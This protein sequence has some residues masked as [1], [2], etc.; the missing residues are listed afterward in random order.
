MAETTQ[1]SIS[2]LLNWFEENKVTYN[3]EALEIIATQQRGSKLVCGNGL[4]VVARRDLIEDEPLVVIPK[5][6][7]ISSATSALANI[8]EDEAVSGSLALCITVMYEIS[9]GEESP[10]FGYL[11]SLP[12]QAD[13]PLLWNSEAQKWLEGTDVGKWV[14]R[15]EQSLRDDFEIV[16]GLVDQYPAIFVTNGLV[17]WSDFGCFLRVTSLVSSRAFM[18]DEFRGNSMVPFADIFNHLT[19]GA[20]VHIE[21]EDQV[22]LLCGNEYGCEH[23]EPLDGSD[24]E[25]NQEDEENEENEEDWDDEN[26]ENDEDED[27]EDEDEDGEEIPILVDQ[28][29]N[30]AYNVAEKMQ[31]DKHESDDS[32]QEGSMVDEADMLSGTLDMV[33][34]QPCKAGS[35]VFNTYGDHG[36]AYLLHRYGFCDTDNIFDSVSLDFENILYA[37]T[38]AISEKRA[39]DMKIIISKFASRLEPCHRA[40]M[41]SEY[42]E[43]EE[44]DEES[45]EEEEK[46]EEEADK[47]PEFSIDAP[48]HPGL[49]LAT[50]LSLAFAADPVFEQVMESPALFR[51]FMPIIRR[52]W[53]AFQDKLDSGASI[54]AALRAA[55]KDSVVKQST[56]GMVCHAIHMLAEARLKQLGDN[57]LLKNKPSDSLQRSRWESAKQLRANEAS[58]LQQC[59]KRY[60]KAA[61]KLM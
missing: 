60:K 39:Q 34:Y 49:N 61:S 54:M 59:I 57:S 9:Q 10:W 7:V 56:V 27:E 1:S 58:V 40:K 48:G 47:M 13:I 28:Q 42:L 25:D 4:G 52:F 5:H 2:V 29:G 26:E 16:Q 37:I 31:I 8:F 51:Q 55:N 17:D 35:E 6:V 22:C 45:E 11:Q 19:N 43:D 18:V 53:A 21:S 38:T 32:S 30:P 36:S 33:V 23:M 14:K 20:S 3:E 44:S 46:E 41:D 24:E 12:R 50:V 15:D